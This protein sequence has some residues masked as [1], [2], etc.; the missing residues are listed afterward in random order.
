MVWNM[1]RSEANAV[2]PNISGGIAH[3]AAESWLAGY[4]SGYNLAS[5]SKSDLLPDLDLYTVS[6]WVD[7]YCQK[8]KNKS[9]PDAVSALFKRLGRDP[10]SSPD[11]RPPHK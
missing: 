9:I 2:P 7:R 8:N 10:V 3:I 5:T 11:S 6:E 1:D 4:I